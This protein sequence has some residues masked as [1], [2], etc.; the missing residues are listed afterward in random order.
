MIRRVV[1]VV[2]N[3]GIVVEDF[4]GTLRKAVVLDKNGEGTC[5]V[6]ACRLP[7]RATTH[8]KRS[9]N[10]SAPRILQYDVMRRMGEG[11]ASR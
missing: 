3:D 5:S 10:M 7:G 8:A 9:D 2:P 6:C 11:R 4:W 1:G